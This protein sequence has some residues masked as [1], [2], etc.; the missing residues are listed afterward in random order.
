M[1]DR[2]VQPRSSSSRRD[3]QD[4]AVSTWSSSVGCGSGEEGSLVD[5]D[6]CQVSFEA[7][8]GERAQ[9]ERWGRDGETTA[10]EGGGRRSETRCELN[11]SLDADARFMASAF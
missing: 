2:Y 6:G 9:W 7:W 8:E 10:T 5:C 1:E 11:E 3:H 4:V